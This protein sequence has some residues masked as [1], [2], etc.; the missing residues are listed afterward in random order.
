MV[1]MD[2]DAGKAWIWT[3]DRATGQIVL[4][5]V[6][7]LEDEPA[8]VALRVVESLRASLNNSGWPPSSKAAGTDAP[9]VVHARTPLAGS[10]R[11]AATLGPAFASGTGSFSGSLGAFGSVY[12]LWAQRWGAEVLGVVAI[13]GAQMATS[14][15]SAR[16][17]FDLVAGGMRARA[18]AVRWCVLDVS[19]GV[20]AATIRTE[21]FPK[22]GYSGVDATTWVATP[23]TKLGYAVSIVPSFFW[24][25]ADLMGAFAIPPLRF[26]F[27]GEDASWGT[28]LLLASIGVEVVLR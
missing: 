18:L 20:G 24:L 25:E 4:R 23:Y 11:S 10:P 9:A 16:L 1:E 26:S 22:P 7:A 28:P 14:A 15:G 5:A 27:A 2:P 8:V 17:V 21:G 6:V 19:A 13:T 12:G 3:V